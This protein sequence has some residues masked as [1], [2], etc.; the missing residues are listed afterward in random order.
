[1]IGE[2]LGKKWKEDL[3]FENYPNLQ[4]I[5]V[6]KKALQYL[7]SMKISNCEKLKSIEIEDYAFYY[8]K[9]VIIESI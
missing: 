4:S 6:K 5:V 3:E 8:V 7:N 9:N 1:M 2:K